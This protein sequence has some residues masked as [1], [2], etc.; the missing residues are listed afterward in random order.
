M[1]LMHSKA[2]LI[3]ITFSFC[4][5]RRWIVESNIAQKLYSECQQDISLCPS[6]QEI[7]CKPVENCS[8]CY[9]AVITKDKC[10]CDVAEC[11]K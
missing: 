6:V 7:G 5:Y 1:S 11:G 10:G 9:N 2:S 4:Y 8:E 3:E